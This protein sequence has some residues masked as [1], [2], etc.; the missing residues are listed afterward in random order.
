MKATIEHLRKG[1]TVLI[2]IGS[3][4]AEVKLLRQPQLAKI[5]KK[6]T[7]RGNPRWSTVLCALREE[8]EQNTTSSGYV[9]SRVRP[10]VANGEDYNIEKRIDFTEK[11]AWIIKRENS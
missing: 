6:T 9:W 5:G 11:V 7:W 3:V 8:K 4:L 1:D 10:V 2:P